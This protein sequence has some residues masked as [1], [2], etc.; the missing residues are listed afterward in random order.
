MIYGSGQNR[1]SIR[2]DQMP[3]LFVVYGLGF[4]VIYG[5]FFLLYGR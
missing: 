1:F 5:I 2:E 4:L 3:Q